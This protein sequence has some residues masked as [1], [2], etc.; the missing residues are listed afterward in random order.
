MNVLTFMLVN[1][2]RSEIE[3]KIRLFESS[4]CY[5]YIEITVITIP[6]FRANGI[7]VLAVR[8]DGKSYKE[9]KKVK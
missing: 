3:F 9:Y 1:D 7:F 6:F 4:H 8:V 5:L 2:I